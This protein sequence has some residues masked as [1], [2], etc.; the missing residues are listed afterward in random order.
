MFFFFFIVFQFKLFILLLIHIAAK[1][2]VYISLVKDVRNAFEGSPLVKIDCKGMHASDYKKLGAK[3][4]VCNIF[5]SS[6]SSGSNNVSRSYIQAC[7]TLLGIKV[8]NEIY[9]QIIKKKIKRRNAL[10]YEL[11]V[12]L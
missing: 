12:Y 7:D 6:N 3:L 11:Q 9:S 5:C 2:G 1:N 4:K 10:K 8:K